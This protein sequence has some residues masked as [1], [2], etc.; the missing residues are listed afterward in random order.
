MCGVARPKRLAK[1]LQH[2]S[3]HGRFAQE[4]GEG[5]GQLVAQLA[6]FLSVTGFDRFEVQSLL[7]EQ[8]KARGTG[9]GLGGKFEQA[10]LV[11]LHQGLALLCYQLAQLGKHR[12]LRA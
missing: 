6:L 3:G 9:L 2:R 1:S 5:G 8:C 11:S 12:G 4:C 10:L 7:L